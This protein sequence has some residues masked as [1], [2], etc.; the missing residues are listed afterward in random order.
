MA[1]IIHMGISCSL[2]LPQD[3]IVQNV[4]NYME[5]QKKC[6]LFVM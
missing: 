2:K 5:A 3:I 4:Y 6:F 1:C